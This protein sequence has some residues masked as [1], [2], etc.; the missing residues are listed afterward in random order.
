MFLLILSL[1]TAHA[2]SIKDISINGYAT[3][4]V[5]VAGFT[6]STY[7]GMFTDTVDITATGAN[8]SYITT[9][10]TKNIDTDHDTRFGFKIDAKT[11]ENVDYQLQLI[12]AGLNGDYSPE[13]DYASIRTNFSSSLSARAG[14]IRIPS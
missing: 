6:G 14:I 12:S 7:D 5:G 10:N 13:I 3:M 11:S 2:A 1:F 4:G 8:P 9:I